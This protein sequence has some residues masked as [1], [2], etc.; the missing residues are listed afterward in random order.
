MS[1]VI[2]LHPEK[3][4]SHAAAP[5]NSS[6]AR[7]L[8]LSLSAQNSGNLTKPLLM[9]TSFF[10]LETEMKQKLMSKLPTQHIIKIKCNK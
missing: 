7:C 4:P 1:S 9:P 5:Q 8:D 10:Y 6:P 2:S 3:Y